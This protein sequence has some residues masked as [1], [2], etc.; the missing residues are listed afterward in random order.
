MLAIG[1]EGH[2]ENSD[3][4]HEAWRGPKLAV[5]RPNASR[6]S[7]V[8]KTFSA[9]VRVDHGRVARATVRRPRFADDTTSVAKPIVEK[10]FCEPSGLVPVTENSAGWSR[11][12]N[13]RQSLMVAAEARGAQADGAAEACG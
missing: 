4:A 10:K 5:A 11:K 2:G 7:A 13:L 12:K 1:T 6:S 9:R 3:F 8:P